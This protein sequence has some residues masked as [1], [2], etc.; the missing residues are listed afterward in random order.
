MSPKEELEPMAMRQSFKLY[1]P[2][3]EQTLVM[4]KSGYHGGF[5]VGHF[6]TSSQ[7]IA[8][9]VGCRHAMME[10]NQ[11][12]APHSLSS[13]RCISVEIL[14]HVHSLMSPT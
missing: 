9:D 4:I 7:P 14:H 10:T 2:L 8:L 11:S 1:Q 12:P 13:T 6:I 3:A 5:K